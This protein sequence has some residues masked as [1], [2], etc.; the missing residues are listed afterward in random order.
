[1]LENFEKDYE[2]CNCKKLTLEYIIQAVQN[3][4]I[5]SL[6]KLQDITKAGTDCRNCLMKEADQGKIKKNIYCSD[7]LKVL[8][9]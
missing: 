6:G 5:K 7:I 2:V 9:G 4:S 1:M 3:Y 8:N